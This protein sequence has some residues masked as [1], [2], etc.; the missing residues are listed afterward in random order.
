MKRLKH[1]FTAGE[2]SYALWSVP[3]GHLQVRL[4]EET[5]EADLEHGEASYLITCD[6]AFTV[7]RRGQ[8]MPRRVFRF[9]AV[10]PAQTAQKIILGD[11][12]DHHDLERLQRF[13]REQL[14]WLDFDLDADD[15]AIICCKHERS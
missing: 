10:S 9:C 5:R 13:C 8:V 6:H 15:I 11:W 14:Y 4:S 1:R 7:E 2:W 3:G 12:F